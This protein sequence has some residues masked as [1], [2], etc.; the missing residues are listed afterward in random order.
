[1]K[2][3]GFLESRA[4]Q[5]ARD[6]IQARNGKDSLYTVAKSAKVSEAILVMNREGIDQI[7]V[8]EG[9]QFVGSVSSA[10]LLEKIIQDPQMQSRQVGEVM[11]KPM[12]FVAPDSTLDVLSSL[13]NKDNKAVLVRD[14]VEKVHIIT[15]HDVL[16]AIT[17]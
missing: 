3:H 12:L 4:F 2:D 8:T 6:I 14:A 11:D 10:S 9:G 17:N 5:S 16:R 1:M 13:L 15:Q 7:P